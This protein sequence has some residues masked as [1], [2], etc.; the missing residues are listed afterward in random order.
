MPI[1]GCILVFECGHSLSGTA[2]L[3]LVTESFRLAVESVERS[4]YA[5]KRVEGL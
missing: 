4:K 3:D 2:D 5:E 1:I